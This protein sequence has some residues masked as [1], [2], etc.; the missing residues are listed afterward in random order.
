MGCMS[1]THKII[2]AVALAAILVVVLV[3][4]CTPK[5]RQEEAVRPVGSG[6]FASTPCAPPLACGPYYSG[7]VPAYFIAHP[8]FSYLSPRGRLYAP[9]VS[10]GSYK[11]PVQTNLPSPAR[12]PMPYPSGYKPVPGDF[13][14]PTAPA[15][16]ATPA[17]SVPASTPM[18]TAPTSAPTHRATTPAEAPA[19]TQR[20]APQPTRAAP[21]TAAPQTQRR[22]TTPRTEPRRAAPAAPKVPTRSRIGR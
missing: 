4:S 22:Q 2:I 3:V 11:R 10:G 9:T 15:S 13:V 18:A 14:P 8:S 6:S 19:Q 21:A 17:A 12:T 20:A 5:K 7:Y 16:G 1:R